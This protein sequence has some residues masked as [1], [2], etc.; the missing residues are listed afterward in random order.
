MTIWTTDRYDR[1][2]ERYRRETGRDAP[3]KDIPAAAYS[4]EEN[5]A[6]RQVDFQ[7]WLA[8]F[9]DRALCEV[10][11]RPPVALT[12]RAEQIREMLGA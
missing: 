5:P 3:G 8:G 12:D 6:V 10:S 2:A 7:L 4:G 9:L 11:L 1:I